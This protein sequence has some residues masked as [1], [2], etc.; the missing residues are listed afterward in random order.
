MNRI[1]MMIENAACTSQ[2]ASIEDDVSAAAIRENV[3]RAAFLDGYRRAKPGCLMSE[4]QAAWDE[5]KRAEG[6][7]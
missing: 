4:S 6:R 1:A 2:N 7:S 3:V 5:Y